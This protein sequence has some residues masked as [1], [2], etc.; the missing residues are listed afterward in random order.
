MILLL[1]FIP[2]VERLLVNI[3]DESDLVVFGRVE[4][5]SLVLLQ[6]LLTR[7]R[8][9]LDIALKHSDC[10]TLVVHAEAKARRLSQRDLLAAK[11]QR[12]R[13]VLGSRIVDVRGAAENFYARDF[14][15]AVFQ[16]KL[17]ELHRRVG[18]DA[19]RA[20]VFK[21]NFGATVAR[22][23]QLGAFNDGQIYECLFVL[24][25]IT[26]DLHTAF[27]V[28]EANNADARFR[29]GRD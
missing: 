29:C 10:R 15:P 27:N 8:I 20:A 13:I 7:R 12:K 5:Q 2:G 21:L 22:G 18:N 19:E 11:H 6:C 23:A 25:G 16:R 26:V 24:S 1:L 17:G 28:A 9:D 3:L 4:L 14:R